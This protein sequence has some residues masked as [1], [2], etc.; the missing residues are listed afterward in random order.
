MRLRPSGSKGPVAA[1]LEAFAAY[2]RDSAWTWEKLALTR[3]RAVCGDPSLM[4]ELTLTI[5]R[6]L[7]SPREPGGVLEDV[8]A[9]RK[10]MLREQGVAGLWDIKR[11]RG[12]LVEVEFIVQTLQ[13]LHAA[14]HPNVLDTNTLGA[15]ER[16]HS[17]G[18]IGE[19]AMATLKSA[20]LLYHRLTQVLR[21]CLAGAYEPG[22]ALPALNQMVASAAGS[23]S[24]AAAEALLF[25]TEGQVAA[26]FDEMVGPAS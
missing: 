9:M 4:N 16:L 25:E 1:S 11:A 7:S 14:R 13:L 17:A 6:S 3:A 22:R 2:H 24:I 12:G 5:R 8:V 15:L 21:L 20:A 18:L 26:L 10:L 19:A 23:P